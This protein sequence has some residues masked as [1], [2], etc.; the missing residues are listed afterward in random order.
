MNTEEII[1][2]LE[3]ELED[4]SAQCE[5]AM[6]KD[7]Q[8]AL[9]Y[10]IKESTLQQILENI[11]DREKHYGELTIGERLKT[12]ENWQAICLEE[13]IP[14]YESFEEYDKE[15]LLLDLMFDAKTLECLG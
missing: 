12:F 14:S 1:E 13:D 9:F 7:V 5:L 11:V 8:A 3:D 10:H 6:G 2:Y 15:Q 4:A